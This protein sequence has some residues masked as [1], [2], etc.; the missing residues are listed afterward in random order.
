MTDYRKDSHRQAVMRNMKILA[1]YNGRFVHRPLLIT[2][3]LASMWGR[4]IV[5]H[6]C[7]NGRVVCKVLCM[8]YA[9]VEK[10]DNAL[11]QFFKKMCSS[12]IYA[13]NHDFNKYIT[14]IS[15]NFFAI[16]REKTALTCNFVHTNCDFSRFLPTIGCKKCD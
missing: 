9:R 16:S 1:S 11:S 6:N 2:A 7:R 10:F 15:C 8:A 14:A 12:A 3:I 13:K 5:S 4:G